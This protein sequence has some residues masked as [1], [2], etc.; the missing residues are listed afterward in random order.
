[1]ELLQVEISVS[2]VVVAPEHAQK[3]PVVA[4]LRNE[5]GIVLDMAREAAAPRLAHK[6]K[7]D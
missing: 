1:M 3:H 7:S 6:G 2:T 5:L 4:L